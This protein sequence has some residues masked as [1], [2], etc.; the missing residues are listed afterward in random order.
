MIMSGVVSVGEKPRPI[1]A[2]PEDNSEDDE[3]SKNG[4]STAEKAEISPMKKQLQKEDDEY[5]RIS[6]IRLDLEVER[7]LTR[8]LKLELANAERE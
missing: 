4:D 8:D 7:R 5:F 6:N 3:D 2:H 1:F